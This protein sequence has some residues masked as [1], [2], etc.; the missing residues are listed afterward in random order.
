M[1]DAVHSSFWLLVRLASIR[2]WSRGMFDGDGD[3]A[4]HTSFVS[5]KGSKTE[6]L[7]FELAS[8]YCFH[9][10]QHLM[11]EYEVAWPMRT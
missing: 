6:K 7:L 2:R 11:P 4:P 8:C 10:R 1:G 3:P 9:E 5:L